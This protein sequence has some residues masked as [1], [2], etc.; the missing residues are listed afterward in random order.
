M[1]VVISPQQTLMSFNSNVDEWI[2]TRF[3][4]S[5]E[6][7]RH[8]GPEEECLGRDRGEEF[9]KAMEGVLRHDKTVLERLAKI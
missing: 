5:R 6:R 8:H 2:E 1:P 3:T 4:R 7:I 9:T